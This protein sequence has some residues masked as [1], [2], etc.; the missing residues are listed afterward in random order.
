M[1][2]IVSYAVADST[3]SPAGTYRRQSP[4][5]KNTGMSARWLTGIGM[6]RMVITPVTTA[7]PPATAT[8]SRPGKR[9]SISLMMSTAAANANAST[10][11]IDTSTGSARRL[12][13]TLSKIGF[14]LRW[15]HSARWYCLPPTPPIV[16]TLPRE[17]QANSTLMI[18]SE[19]TAG[20]RRHSMI[21]LPT[22]TTSRIQPKNEFSSVWVE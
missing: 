8:A 14:V 17:P 9:W 6:G 21:T 12:G 18:A 2:R 13:S 16:T 5:V 19:R 22:A 1:L 4:L 15:L 3:L 11:P 20:W 7:A 10:T